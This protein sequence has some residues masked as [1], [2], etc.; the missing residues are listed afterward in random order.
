MLSGVL[1]PKG[2]I[3]KY[4]VTG[5]EPATSWRTRE[6]ND[7]FWSSGTS[8]FGFGDADEATTIGFG[9][10]VNNKYVTTYF[11][12]TFTLPASFTT[13]QTPGLALSL[14]RDDGAVVFLNGSEVVR[15]NLPVGVIQSGTLALTAI[16]GQ[17]ESAFHQYIINPALLLPGANVIAVEI[18]QA[19]VNSS[20]LSFDLALTALASAPVGSARFV[21]LQPCRIADTRNAPGEFGGPI[22]SGN[23]TRTFRLPFSTCGIPETAKAYS[24]NV[25]VVPLGALGYLTVYP[26]GQP[27]PL[28]S[29]L[30]SPSG[31]VL[32]NA[33]IAVAGTSGSIDVYA[34][35]S[36]HV[37][38]DINGYYDNIDPDGA[39]FFAL[40]PCRVSDT[41]NPAAALG[42]PQ[43]NSD[44]SRT[45]PVSASSCG[46]PVNA[47][48]YSMN[49]T[50]VPS[51]GLGYLTLWP[52]GGTMPV[53]STL[54]SPAGQVIANSAVVVGGSGGVS[55]FVTNPTHLILDTNGYFSLSGS[56]VPLSF[57]PTTP[58]RISDTRN[59]NGSFGGPSISGGTTR[60]FVISQ[61]ACNI[62]NSAKAYSLNITVVPNGPLGYLGIWPAGQAQ[63]LV[64]TLNSPTGAVIANAAIVPG[65][66]NGAVSVFVTNTSHVILDI[67]GYFAP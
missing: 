54:N 56:G 31:A 3:W 34:S 4:L 33:A 26:T 47:R 23:V 51:G 45:F 38:L 63:P 46:L 25:T 29:T 13:N 2:A 40:N 12:H 9:P 61:S 48:A 42:G 35:N 67:N 62:P 32:A 11:R 22:I 59:A 41:R 20:D 5:S 37:I 52:A 27:R 21:P 16:G 15:S 57:Y 36:T 28:V 58:C 60:D 1:A 66:A 43:M 7:S 55:A 39:P 30:N 17:D 44:Q 14:L 50:V 53:V 65:S 64:S 10:D 24:L 18:H 6:Y 8:Q 19:S 49:A